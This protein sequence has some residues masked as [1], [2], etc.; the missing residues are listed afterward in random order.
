MHTDDGHIFRKRNGWGDPR[1]VSSKSTQCRS[2]SQSAQSV[3]THKL[4]A[5]DLALPTIRNRI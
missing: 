2:S 4:P 5:Y 1:T 3:T